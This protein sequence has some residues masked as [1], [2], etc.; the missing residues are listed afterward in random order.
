MVGLYCRGRLLH[1]VQLKK[2]ETEAVLNPADGVG[3]VC[4]V[5]VFEETA[6]GGGRRELTPVAERLI[7]RRPAEYLTVN[8]TPDRSS[9]VP[10]DKAKLRVET[11][12]EK[13]K[14]AP[15][16]VMAA[17]VD[18]S[19]LTLADEKTHKAMPTHFLLTSEVR[20]P[21]D[22]EYADFLLGPQAKASEALDLLLGVQGWRRFAEQDPDK[23]REK[24]ADKE[25]AERLLVM[26][27]QSPHKTDLAREE[28]KK[29]EDETD[30]RAARLKEQYARADEEGQAALADPLYT[31]AVTRTAWY[32][33]ALERL[34]LTGTPLACAALCG[35]AA[36]PGFGAE[37]RP[38]AR[39]PF[40][41][42]AAAS[43]VLLVAVVASHRTGAETGGRRGGRAGGACWTIRTAR[44]CRE[45]QWTRRF[46]R[47][48]PRPTW[49]G[50]NK[51][52]AAAEKAA[53][54]DRAGCARG[55]QRA[56]PGEARRGQGRLTSRLRWR[57][58]RRASRRRP[59]AGWRGPPGRRPR[60]SAAAKAPSAAVANLQGGARGQELQEREKQF[61]LPRRRR[62]PAES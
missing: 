62:A 43:V 48:K 51:D 47:T 49:D 38:A 52:K 3:G 58:P 57:C 8:L 54:D 53:M 35:G 6:A 2:G 55:G 10:G 50:T 27:G 16:V 12:D 40:Y 5:T 19:V 41:A 46:G 59:P 22:L 14:P 20:R 13:G 26:T 25:E 24:D 11:L 42:A 31:A 32:G 33:D 39:V 45:P 23:F 15:A 56:R 4:R 60:G 29:I 7:Y 36:L 21:E 37:E 30:A 61:G 44:G 34:R 18:K 9:Y 1:S 28:I 17:V